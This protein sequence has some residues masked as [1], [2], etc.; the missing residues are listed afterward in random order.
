MATIVTRPGEVESPVVVDT[1]VISMLFKHDPRGLP[2]VELLRGLPLVA[3]F[4]TYAELYQWARLRNWGEA[5]LEELEEF[6]VDYSL[7]M[8]TEELCHRWAEVRAEGRAAGRPI[9]AQDAWHAALALH[10]GVPLVT[11][12]VRDFTMLDHLTIMTSASEE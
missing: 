1:D 7:M 6:L 5:R 9:S 11:H 12:N 8:S 3:S 4:M 10:F 2:Y